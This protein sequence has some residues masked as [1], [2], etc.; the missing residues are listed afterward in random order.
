MYTSAESIGNIKCNVRVNG[1]N[2]EW[3]NV[4]VTL[5]QGCF[6]SSVL[7]NMYITYLVI[8]VLHISSGIPIGDENV[9]SLMCADHSVLFARSDR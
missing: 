7:F 1:S 9:V 5:Q 4:S 3:F 8:N 2:T 6:M